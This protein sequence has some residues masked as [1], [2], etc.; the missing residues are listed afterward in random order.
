MVV[1]LCFGQ[2]EDMASSQGLGI[3]LLMHANVL[4]YPWT[5]DSGVWQGPSHKVIEPQ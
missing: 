1:A 3:G 4:L 2:V 5:R